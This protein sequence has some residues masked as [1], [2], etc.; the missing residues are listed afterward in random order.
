MPFR[1][2]VVLALAPALAAAVALA[3]LLT[4]PPARSDVAS[5]QQGIAADQSREQSLSSGVSALSHI[6]GVLHAQLV[7]MS[8]RV[9]TVQAQLNTDEI[10]LARLS[11]QTVHER[12]RAKALAAQFLSQRA[13]LARWLV[14]QYE[15]GRPDGLTVIL[16][17]NGFADLLE[18]IDFLER[19]GSEDQAITD[20]TL[21]AR[22]ASRLA[23]IQLGVLT[24]RQKRV[25][26]A[27]QSENDALQA[28]TRALEA[29]SGELAQARALKEAELSRTRS[30]A[31]SLQGQL[32]HLLATLDTP[33]GAPPV[34]MSFAI[35]WSV[36]DCES[37]GQNLPPN[38]AGASGYYQIIPSTWS[39][40]GGSGPAAYLTPKSEQDVVASRIWNGGKGA[41]NWVC[42]TLVG[43]V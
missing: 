4:A 13:Q 40:F 8:G 41:S 22:N 28:M 38:S 1:R 7:V 2:L 5:L 9:A 12:A 31:H 11:T 17:A 25:T 43:I 35:P 20:G 29:R 36:V 21:H 24:A 37:G 15:Y 39:L 27:V 14:A 26:D 42:A 30:D 33:F 16:E 3:L 18:R 32:S 19:I 34:G 6:I 10:S 23:A